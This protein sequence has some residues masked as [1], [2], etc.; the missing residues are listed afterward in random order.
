M[1]VAV[2]RVTG[3]QQENNI[4]ADILEGEPKVGDMVRAN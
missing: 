4:V 2:V 3:P 1:K